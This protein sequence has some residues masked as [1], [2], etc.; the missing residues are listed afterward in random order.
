[1][2]KISY[3]FNFVNNM[4]LSLLF[5]DPMIF[6]AWLIAI[7]FAL[8]IHE[9]A[10]AY[11]ALKQGD[12]TAKLMGR[13]S[14]N[15]LV[16]IDTFGLISIV[17]IGFGWGKPVPVNPFYFK[18]KKWGDTLVSFAGPLS[19]FIS[20]IIFIV[21]TRFI[22]SYGNFTPDNLMIQFFLFL[23]MINVALGV[24]NLIPIPPL[25]GHH[26]LFSLLPESFNDFKV[27][28]LKNGPT[29][30]LILI[31]ADNLFNIGI[32]APLFNLIFGGLE[33]LIF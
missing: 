23:I 18:N 4:I 10:H 33:K 31:L 12:P 14:L 16:H 15:P 6:V 2:I 1:M 5:T 28:L 7:I 20:A 22:I 9:F 17:L 26:I 29:F 21:A 30:L 32:F 19:N 27:W 24:F 25:D 13:L 3:F 8:T 11:M